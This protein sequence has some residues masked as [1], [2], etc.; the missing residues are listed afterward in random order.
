M[1]NIFKF[2]FSTFFCIILLSGCSN[3]SIVGN[4]K[5]FLAEDVK[6]S[7]VEV[8]KID[9]DSYSLDES[10][11]ESST[12]DI[13]ANYRNDC[14]EFGIMSKEAKSV[15]L[16]VTLISDSGE[17]IYKYSMKRNSDDVWRA[18][19]YSSKMLDSYSYDAVDNN[20]SRYFLSY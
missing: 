13:G 2:V 16:C 7:I 8:S 18:K 4:N 19:I 9:V 5:D 14:I 20:G 1:K 10:C 11:W 15:S 6:N 12:W 17:K 3:S